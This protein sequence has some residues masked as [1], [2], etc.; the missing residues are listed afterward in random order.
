M[1]QLL[2]CE[3]SQDFKKFLQHNI[4][5]YSIPDYQREYKW[6]KSRIKTFVTNV[7]DRSKFLGILTAEGSDRDYLSIVDGQQRLTTTVLLLAWLYNACAEEGERE[8]QLEI[9][10]LLTYLN[11]NSRD[12]VLKNDSVGCFL[13]VVEDESLGSTIQLNV[14]DASDIYHQK[15]AFETAWNTITSVASEKWKRSERTLQDYKEC[16][17]DCGVLLF[18][19]NNDDKKQQGS[20]EEIYIDI[21]EKSQRL[22]PEDIF[23]GHCFALCKTPKTQEKVKT[24]WK[25]LKQQLYSMDGLWDKRDMS[26]FLHFYLL[27]MEACKDRPRDINK[28]LKIAGEHIISL[29]YKT[30][31]KVI[32]LL[33]NIDHYLTNLLT[34]RKNMVGCEVPTFKEV[35]SASAN[36]IGNKET[37]ALLQDMRTI[38]KDLFECKQDLFKL[39]MFYVIDRYSS[40]ADAEKLSFEQWSA[41]V[42]LYNIY[43]FIFARMGVSKSR[44]SLP[45]ELIKYT[46]GDNDFINQLAKTIQ[47]TYCKG[48]DNS[49]LRIKL[50]MLRGKKRDDETRKHLYQILDYFKVKQY[51]DKKTGAVSTRYKMKLYPAT[52]N[53]EHLIISQSQGI[54]WK[55]DPANPDSNTTYEF[56]KLDFSGCAAW[57]A[58]NC[59]WANYIWID[60]NFNRKELSNND[61]VTKVHLLRGT[62]DKDEKPQKETFAK[63]HTHIEVICQH[64]MRTKGFDELV[65]AHNNHASKDEIIASYISFMDSYFS[66]D[67]MEEL[68][69]RINEAFANCLNELFNWVDK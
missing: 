6:D 28:E 32:D 57:C 63:K 8:N 19:Q 56:K 68:C 24:L 55:E 20:I 59:H 3:F 69:H 5:H 43:M 10:E 33:T 23:K 61:I 34:F 62:L 67:S 1:N 64:I 66:E 53:V 47:N 7:L 36:D 4:T 13:K 31:T 48:D 39:P 58:D 27:T 16:L 18:V 54:A 21:N 45:K 29:E 26:I 14:S 60:D 15:E 2:R 65:Q 46:A 9:M 40:K 17:L 35:M 37:K 12:F 50:G 22:D 25:S 49:P 52:Y 41:F 11:N 42:F 38:L 44:E 51:T 30:S